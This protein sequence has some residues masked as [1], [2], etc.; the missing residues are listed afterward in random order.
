MAAPQVTNLAGKL[1]AIDPRLTPERVV[2]LIK[3]TSTKSDD[4]RRNLMN[5]AEALKRLKGELGK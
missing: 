1:F 4:Q 3:E 2:T 5:P